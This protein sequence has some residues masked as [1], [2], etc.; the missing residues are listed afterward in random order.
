MLAV[1]GPEPFHAKD[2]SASALSLHSLLC[3][4]RWGLGWTQAATALM[5]DA[6]GQSVWL[7]A[8]VKLHTCQ[9]NTYRI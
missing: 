4:C 6:Q 9:H 5:E 2:K 3:T 1:A 7:V 8:Q